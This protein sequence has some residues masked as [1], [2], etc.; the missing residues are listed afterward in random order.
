MSVDAVDPMRP[1]SVKAIGN[2]EP[3]M[4]ERQDIEVQVMVDQIQLVGRG[5]RSSSTVDFAREAGVCGVVGVLPNLSD[6]TDHA[7][8]HSS[9]RQ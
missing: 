9:E 6:R 4:E 5:Q 1:R 7:A 8:R 3:W 2:L